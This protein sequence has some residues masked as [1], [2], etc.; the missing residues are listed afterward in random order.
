MLYIV[1]LLG[2][3]ILILLVNSLITLSSL[4]VLTPYRSVPIKPCT[5][6]ELISLALGH[7][8]DSLRL[9]SSSLPPQFAGLE[10]CHDRGE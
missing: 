4:F 8:H 9:R 2:A 5:S 10:V 6:T 7:P 1:L 3:C